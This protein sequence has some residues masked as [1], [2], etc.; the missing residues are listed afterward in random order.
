M[1]KQVIVSSGQKYP[2]QLGYYV[3]SGICY[4][5]GKNSFQHL[6]EN[7]YVD[8]VKLNLDASLK[9]DAGVAAA[10]ARNSQGQIL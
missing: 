6:L 4:G 8:Y 3:N 5:N 7:S 1:A 2:Y 10:V 9:K